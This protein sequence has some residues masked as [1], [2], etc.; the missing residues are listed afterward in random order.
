[1]MQL[2]EPTLEEQNR[3]DQVITTILDCIRSGTTIYLPDFDPTISRPSDQYAL[4]SVGIEPN[5][6][7]GSAGEYRYQ[8]EGEEDLLHL[9]IVRHDGE[10]LNPA[11]SQAVASFLYPGVPTAMMWYKAGTVSHHFYLGHDILLEYLA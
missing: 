2:L 9:I 11:E 5:P 8:F 6:Y 7:G 3:R 1:M 4:T 10:V